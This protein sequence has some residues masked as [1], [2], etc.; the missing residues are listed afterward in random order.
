MGNIDWN[1]FRHPKFLQ[2]LTLTLNELNIVNLFLKRANFKIEANQEQLRET[3]LA[4][5][6]R[7]L[8]PSKFLTQEQVSIKI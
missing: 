5:P 1:N 6:R 3:T 4:S 7:S 8:N 2:S